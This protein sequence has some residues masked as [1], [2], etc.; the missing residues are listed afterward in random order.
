MLPVLRL[1]LTS[2]SYLSINT[3][4]DFFF[5]LCN[6]RSAISS[7]CTLVFLNVCLEFPKFP[8]AFD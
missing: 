7:S 5:F 4:Y 8:N 6:V 3:G 2:L 1:I